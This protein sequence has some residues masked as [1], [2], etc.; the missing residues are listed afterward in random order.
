MVRRPFSVPQR[1]RWGRDVGLADRAGARSGPKTSAGFKLRHQRSARQFA[2]SGPTALRTNI[3]I[4]DCLL[5][6]AMAATGLRTTRKVVEA[7]LRI[8][9]RQKRQADARKLFASAWMSRTTP[10]AADERARRV[11]TFDGPL[12][13]TATA[14]SIR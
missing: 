1:H 11:A 10:I 5:A 6:E 8:L 9:A 4:D 7:R 14:I 2:H 12:C 13:C 3:E